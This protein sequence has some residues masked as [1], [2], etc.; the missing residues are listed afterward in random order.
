M[1][2]CRHNLQRDCGFTLIEAAMTTV[3]IGVGILASMSLFAACSQQNMNSSEMTTAMM[4][5]TNIQEAMA[6]LAFCDP[7][8]GKTTFGPEGGETLASY[9][10]LDDF[11][12]QTISPPIDALR[13]SI[14]NLSQYSQVINVDPVDPNNLSV[15]LPKTITNRT[16]VRIQ[17]HVYFKPVTGGASEE[18]YRTDWVRTEE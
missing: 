2:I 10:D 6:N 3:I 4:L 17:V 15:T 9:D 12:G 18:V 5:A 8:T 13:A 14:P 1:S 11:D 7:I 16:A